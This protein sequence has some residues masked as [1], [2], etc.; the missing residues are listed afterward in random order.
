[1]HLSHLA[2]DHI[3]QRQTAAL[4]EAEQARLA[5]LARPETTPLWQHWHTFQRALHPIRLVWKQQA[6][7]AR[8]QG[9]STACCPAPT[10]PGAH[11]CGCAL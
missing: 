5:R 7:Q 6:A 3:Y 1:M 8:T 11:G 10:L 9:L 4:R 2:S